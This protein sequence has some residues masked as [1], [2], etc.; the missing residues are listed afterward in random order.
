MKRS[1]KEVN[2]SKLN[3]YGIFFIILTVILLLCYGGFFEGAIIFLGMITA[4]VFFGRKIKI[5]VNL[6]QGIFLAFAL[7]YFL[8]SIVNGFVLE[9]MI[10]GLI[11]FITFFLWIWCSNF[12]GAKE[13][14]KD[15][16]VE[17][18][19]WIAVISIIHCG[20]I[21]IDSVALKRITF[22]FDYSNACG[23]YF[24][25]CYFLAQQSRES[26]L[27]KCKY[28]FIVALLLTQS[29]GAIGLFCLAVFWEMLKNKK[30]LYVAVISFAGLLFVILFR[31]RILES[32]GTFVE[33]LLQINDGIICMAKNPVFGIGAGWWENAKGH[34]QTGYYMAKNIHSSIVSIGV[35]SGVLGLLLFLVVCFLEVRKMITQKNVSVPVIL[36]LAHSLLDFTLS[37]MAIN[38]I[39]VLLL[40]DNEDEKA[41]E[42][43]EIPKKIIAVILVITFGLFTFGI[44]CANVF[45]KNTKISIEESIKTF[46]QCF[47]VN[48]SIRCNQYFAA[49]MYQE[50]ISCTKLQDCNYKYMPIEVVL[51]KSE[52][53]GGEGYLLKS[54]KEQPYNTVLRDFILSGSH[55]EEKVSLLNKE[56]V[57]KASF[58]GRI[59]YN[60]KG[61]NI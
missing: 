17:I 8:C 58:F 48:H 22:P 55:E 30:Y 4:G 28:V 11:P 29:V 19:V 12:Q 60:L 32:A 14:V 37:F 39:L 1:I 54:L 15:V 35:N 2:M 33:R 27:K 21:S 31:E 42:I 41:V 52:Y 40:P 49:M 5:K 47:F 44:A 46:D 25:V 9:Y 57:E 45:Q 20:I 36:I 6:S 10:R 23:I 13:K 18:S 24:A 16:I 53:E 7:W 50:K 34:Y 26:F 51:Y 38:A 59:L 3:I 43:K 61:E 56:S